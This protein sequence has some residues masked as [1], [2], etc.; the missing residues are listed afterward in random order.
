MRPYRQR[1]PVLRLTPAN[2]QAALLLIPCFINRRYRSRFVVNGDGPGVHRRLFS[3][4]MTTAFHRHAMRRP[5]ESALSI[6]GPVPL[7]IPKV[8]E[9]AVACH[10]FHEFDNVPGELAHLAS[11]TL[12]PYFQRIANNDRYWTMRCSTRLSHVALAIDGDKRPL[13]LIYQRPQSALPRIPNLAPQPPGAAQRQL[14]PAS[15]VRIVVPLDVTRR[16]VWIQQTLRYLAR[17]DPDRCGGLRDWDDDPRWQTT[18]EHVARLALDGHLETRA[19]A[20]TRLDATTDQLT[21]AV[22]DARDAGRVGPQRLLTGNGNELV[23][24]AGDALRALGFEITEPDE[25]PARD[26]DKLEDLQ[27]RDPA[28][29]AWVCLIEVRGYGG[30]AKVTD[31]LRIGRF[32][33]RYA[34]ATGAEPTSR[35]YIANHFRNDPPEHRAPPL[36][37]NP[38]E[39]AVFAGA[40]GLVIDSRALFQLL[41]RHATD[42]PADLAALRAALRDRTGTLTT[43]KDLPAP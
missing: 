17:I 36:A 43:A 23:A 38:S 12:V 40:G 25:S 29:P 28:A 22:T 14:P 39:V 3:S 37:P 6:P 24:A 32:C 30:G 1:L 42:D 11:T 10:E 4:D 31:L 19:A 27:L 21:A 13:G 34:A 26:G 7:D 9:H 41:Q 33:E 5:P 18:A 16:D 8:T 35:W 2:R 15:G 20:I